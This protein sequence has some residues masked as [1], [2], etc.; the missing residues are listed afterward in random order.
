MI[1]ICVS[2]TNARAGSWPGA[3]G[4]VAGLLLS[5]ALLA[6]PVE[7][8]PLQVGGRDIEQEGPQAT[9]T[10]PKERIERIRPTH[11][12]E[13][14]GRLPGVEVTRG[15]GQEHLTAVRSPLLTGAG[16]CGG[17]LILEAGV[18]IRPPGFCNA[19]NLFEVN[20]AQA[21]AVSVLRGPGGIGH[22]SGGLHG[23]IDIVPRLD[24]SGGHN[25]LSMEAGSDDYY[26][27]TGRLAGAAGPGQLGAD[28]TAVDSGSFR[29]D[30]KYDHQLAT[31]QYAAGDWRG[32]LSA[33]RLDQDTAG[34]VLGRN[35]YADPVLRRGNNNPEAWRKADALR[36][37]ARRQWLDEQGGERRL[38][39]FARRSAMDFRQ[40]YLPGKPLEHNGQTSAGLQL[41]LESA[42]GW[43]WGADAELFRGDLEQFQDRSAD[44]AAPPVAA[45]R[46]VGRHYDYVVDGQRAGG[47]V[48]HRLEWSEGWSLRAG[49]HADWI[50][51]DYKNRMAPGNLADDGSAC[52]MGGCLYNRP[53]SR[54]DDFFELA[55]EFTVS[56]R[57]AFGQAWLRLARGFRAPQA[58]ELYRLQRGQDV[59]D[60]NPEILD[61][62]EIGVSVKQLFDWE[63]VAWYQYKR[64][65][66]LRDNQGFNISSGRLGQRGLEF[67]ARLPLGDSVELGVRGSLAR[68]WYRFD[69]SLDGGELIQSGR[70]PPAAPHFM[71]SA[72]IVWKPSAS[73]QVELALEHTGRYWLD[74]ENEHRY[75]GHSLLHLAAGHGLTRHWRVDVR[76]RN[77]LNRRHAERADFA[78]GNYRYFPGPGRSVFVVLGW[79]AGP[80][81]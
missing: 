45:I 51:Y 3:A 15:S 61:S 41:D 67:A 46:P 56:H 35:A 78:F 10:L 20:L 4:L 11:P 42:G 49:V 47:Y 81:G 68:H 59:A 66:I 76:L 40:H 58:T 23:V 19:N 32:L 55:P 29:V 25:R 50:R 53:A 24:L 6:A 12:A 79:R 1:K 60:L 54:S 30:E 65:E 8:E 80:G 31:V 70:N 16:A 69:R 39:L 38:S 57:G 52:D 77:V 5:C 44:D 28:F 7:L 48:A 33:A 22:A 64:N 72:D 13:L 73:T 27:L 71:G 21:E 36:L 74:A 14:F 18:P 75:G 37:I 63:L 34:Y 62:A 43:Q 2:S 17:L 26:R 9:D